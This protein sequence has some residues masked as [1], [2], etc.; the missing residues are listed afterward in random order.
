MSAQVTDE[1]DSQR[2]TVRGVAL[3][4]ERV[5]NASS[6][7]KFDRRPRVDDLVTFESVAWRVWP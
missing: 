5:P 1:S 6:D 7:S 2:S 3:I 4:E